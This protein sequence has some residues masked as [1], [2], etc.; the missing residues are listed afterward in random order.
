MSRN[1]ISFTGAADA[2]MI[3]QGSDLCHTMPD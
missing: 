1:P 3:R 2:W